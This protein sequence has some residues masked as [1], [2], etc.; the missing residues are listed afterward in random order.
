M[1]PEYKDILYVCQFLE[2]KQSSVPVSASCETF[3]GTSF[4]SVTVPHLTAI[5]QK[6]PENRLYNTT[7]RTAYLISANYLLMCCCISQEKLHRIMNY[8]TRTS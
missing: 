4:C 7:L 6:M 1:D 2:A 3:L 5:C 8:F